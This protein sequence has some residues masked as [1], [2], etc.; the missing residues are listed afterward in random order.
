MLAWPGGGMRSVALTAKQP[1]SLAVETGA[2]RQLTI[3]VMVEKRPTEPVWLS[4]DCGE[5]CGGKVEI[6]GLLNGLELNR[7]HTV[8]TSLTCFAMQGADMNRV[9]TPFRVSTSG[10]MTLRFADIELVPSPISTCSP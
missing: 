4:L 2:G 6:T 1:V 5:M 7:W 9:T 10:S 3:E 8:G